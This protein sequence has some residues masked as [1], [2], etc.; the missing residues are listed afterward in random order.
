MW[1]SVQVTQL[2]RDY[3][4]MYELAPVFTEEEVL[5]YLMPVEGVMQTHVV[6]GRGT[7]LRP[8]LFSVPVRPIGQSCNVPHR[9]CWEHAAFVRILLSQ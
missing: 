1:R 5:H 7:R 2:L 6:E 4:G 9:C 3:L 8:L